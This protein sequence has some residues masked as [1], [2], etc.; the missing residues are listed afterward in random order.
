M[1]YLYYVLAI[2][3]LFA[4][5]GCNN[6]EEVG[7]APDKD[8]EAIALRNEDA[9]YEVVDNPLSPEYK[10]KEQAKYDKALKELVIKDIVVGDGQEV[11]SGDTVKVKYT[12]KL[13]N[14]KIFDS[15]EK[16]E[17]K[18][19][20]SFPIGEGKVIKGW[21]LGLVGMKVG[22]KRHLD[23]PPLFGY[24]EQD[25]GPIP[26]NSTLHFDIELVGIE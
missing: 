11:K 12:G 13:D 5:I 18:A 14:G 21:D 26:A 6:G 17:T 15:T 19:P 23:I 3:C 7:V 25:A 1:K 22:G 20:V 2:I 8:T 4:L 10:A 24:G 9:Y 16:S